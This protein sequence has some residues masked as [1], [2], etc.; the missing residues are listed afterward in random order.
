MPMKPILSYL[1]LFSLLISSGVIAREVKPNTA[2]IRCGW[3]D[4]PT[5][6]NAWLMDRDGEW[7]I[8]IQGGYQAE[9]EWPTFTNSQ[10]I[11]T[12]GGY[13]YGCACLKVIADQKTREVSRIISTRAVPLSQCRRDRALKEPT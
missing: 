11:K 12:N 1:I 13:G 3:F 8:G 10:W 5:P 4:N 9:G 6:G 7:V 2:S